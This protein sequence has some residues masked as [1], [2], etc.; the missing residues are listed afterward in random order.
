MF[1]QTSAYAHRPHD[2]VTQIETSQNYDTNQTVLI[3]VRGNLF[4]SSDGGISWQ[5][6]TSGLDIQLASN[7][8]NLAF[9]P[10]SN[11]GQEEIFLVSN[12]EGIFRSQDL[13]ST[14]AK[15]DTGLKSLEIQHIEAAK[16]E[17]RLVLASDVNGRVYQ[18]AANG[19]RWETALE[20]E[21]GDIASIDISLPTGVLKAVSTK[22]GR[23]WLAKGDAK[24]WEQ[25]SV[26]DELNPDEMLATIELYADETPTITLLVG[27]T[28]GRVLKSTDEG[29]SWTAIGDVLNGSIVDIETATQADSKK[30]PSILV[31]TD[32]NGLFSLTADGRWQAQQNGLKTDPQ[33]D[34]MSEPNFGDLE[35]SPDGKM[36]FIA[37]FDGFFRSTD[38]GQNWES[39]ETLARD[40]IVSL[41]VS[42]NYAN[43]STLAVAS[44]VGHL[45]LSR[46]GGETWEITN[47]G[48]EMPRFTR[49]FDAVEPNYDPR[50][51]FD[52]QFS[53]TY[54]IDQTILA[55]TL[56]TKLAV[57]N[58]TGKSWDL[59]TMPKTMRGLTIALSPDYEQDQMLFVSSQDKNIYISTNNAKDFAVAG[60]RPSF[61]GNYGSSLVVSPNFKTDQTLFTSGELGIYKSE[62]SGK[63]W[64]AITR[65]MQTEVLGDLQIAVSPNYAVD[66]TLFLGTKSGL[67]QSTDAGE[68]W[69]ELTISPNDDTVYIEAVAISPNYA[70]DQTA[71]VSV[72]GYGLFKTIDSGTSFQSIGDTQIVMSRIWNI[73]SSG[74]AIVFSPDYATDNTIY[75]FGSAKH[76]VY[77]SQDGGET[78]S[79]IDIP[80]LEEP[81]P[82]LLESI[83]IASF[84]YA[85]FLK[86]A[87][88]V[89]FVIALGSM[90]YL[91]P[92]F[93]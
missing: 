12:H 27:T 20:V 46:D 84:V 64:E 51:F 67:F 82:V 50:R 30:A 70:E 21:N 60:E 81:K 40:T 76:Q 13:G 48:L 85:S 33:A 72:R 4:R 11:S 6:I 83:G 1:S 10:T 3:L 49:K 89:I 47:K 45:Y 29:N 65:D 17:N 8:A 92:K 39:V 63:N 54:S 74:R 62:D 23:L 68:T 35:I 53:P 18:L 22:D 90:I 88:V 5:R 73:P 56:W 59:R 26:A 24:N 61:N 15:F 7:L 42:P 36:L 75:G 16:G 38:Q 71:I 86:K 19:E 78:W 2:V 93:K 41:A 87:A 58:D 55:S 69:S 34:E 77:R 80:Q 31:S 32:E 25:R 57:T 28:A 66:R 52:I 37:G 9:S 43:D 44:Y 14:W 91:F 79:I